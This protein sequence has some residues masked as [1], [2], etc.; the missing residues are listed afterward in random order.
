MARSNIH[1][2]GVVK[3]E[4][5]GD[6]LSAADAFCLSS[7]IEGMPRS[8]IEVYACGCTPNCTP[9]GRMVNTIQHGVSRFLSKTDSGRDYRHAV[10]AF[11]KQRKSI[12]K[13]KLVRDYEE[14]F[15][16]E[17]CAE[18]YAAIYKK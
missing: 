8:L 9:V 4:T 17:N 12:N 3:N 15:T 11:I 10:E 14:N 1:F 5:I 18:K 2:M 13:N 6:Y 7:V 16:I